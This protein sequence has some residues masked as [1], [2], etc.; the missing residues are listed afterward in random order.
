MQPLGL[1][2][3][4]GSLP[5]IVCDTARSRGCAVAAAAFDRASA[6]GLSPLADTR[7]FGIGQAEEVIGFLKK[8]G[9]AEVVIIG[10]FEKSL[11]FD[12]SALKPDARAKKIWRSLADKEDSSIMRAII[13]ELESE[14]LKVARQTDWIPQLI[15]SAGVL[16]RTAPAPGMMDEIKRGMEICRTLAGKEIGQTIIMKDGVVLAVEA[17]E[18]TNQTVKRGCALG[19]KGAMMIKAARPAQDPRFDIPAV[20]LATVKLLAEHGAAA[21]AIEAGGVVIVDRPEATALC[22]THRILFCAV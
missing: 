20:G 22:D 18:G 6:K 16:G 9:C 10:K 17:V 8:S 3:G 1:I 14:G 15:P 11:A 4:K 19:G 5:R 7:L 21:L 2:A 12:F 13:A